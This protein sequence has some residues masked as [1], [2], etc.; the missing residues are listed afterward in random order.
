MRALGDQPS[1][2]QTQQEAQNWNSHNSVLLRGILSSNELAEA[3]APAYFFVGNSADHKSWGVVEKSIA[4]KITVLKGIVDRLHHYPEPGVGGPSRPG[5]GSRVF[6]VHGHDRSARNAIEAFL[7]RLGLEPILLER[8]PNQGRTVAE[9]LDV[10]A[11][12]AFA[13]IV[14]SPDDVGGLKG[15][16]Q[17]ERAR[18]NVVLEH[19][20]FSAKLGRD[21]IAVLRTGDL[22]EPSDTA[23]IV[24]IRM[25]DAEGWMLKLGR[26]L[27][28]AGLRVDLNRLA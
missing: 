3:Y 1:L 15:K 27:R 18:Q 7:M 22:E 2:E 10:N 14:M 11:D 12:V 23:G 8:Q 6:V 5:L 24:Y 13:V 16:E 28:A 4:G 25:D 19:G 9:K 21:R 26:E 20:Y 17:S